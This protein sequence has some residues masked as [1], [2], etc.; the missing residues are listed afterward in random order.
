MKRKVL[1]L[2]PNY[3]NKYPPIGLMK[4]ATYHRMLGD[5]VRFYKG[6]M[7]DFFIDEIFQDCLK[8]LENFAALEIWKELEFE[9]KNFIK[10]RRKNNLEFLSKVNIEKSELITE[11]LLF[12]ANYYK[13]KEYIN[14]PQWDRIFV[15]TL[16]TFYWKKT[17]E[18]IH[19]A[20][21]LVKDG[22]N[23]MVGGVLASLLPEELELETGIKP[24]KGIL[25]R[26]GALDDN[27]IIIDDLP[28]D[29]SILD[30]IDYK[31]PTGSAYFTFMTKGCTRK[32]AFCSV[33]ILEPTYK[34]KIDTIDKFKQI[35]ENYGEQQNLLLMDN[36][37]LA[38]PNFVEIID[39]IKEMGFH[40]GATFVEPNQFE[41][42]IKNLKSGYNDRANTKRCFNLLNQ[43]LKSKSKRKEIAGE[44][45]NTMEKYGLLNLN[46]TTK[47]NL[48][49]AYTEL[50]HLYEKHRKK[51]KKLRY[52]D[53]NQGTDARYVTDELMQKMSE[54]PIRPLRIAFD[55]L[56]ME[57]QY[58]SAVRLAAK[59]DIRDLSN[60]LLFNFKD[61]PGELYRRM[62]IN[63]ELAKELNI[64]IFSFPMKYIPLFGEEAKHRDYVGKHWNKKFIRAIQ[65]ILNVTKGIVASGSNFFHI[66]FGNNLEE[67]NEIL[68]MPETY[69]IYRNVFKDSGLTD[70]WRKEFYR[71]KN[72]DLWE[73]VK[74]IIENSDFKNLQ[75]K[76]SHPELLLFLSHYQVSKNDVMEDDKEIENIRRRFNNL[77]KKDRFV[78]L[79]LTYDYE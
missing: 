78:N 74:Q 14:N 29:Y 45:S 19:A 70:I 10:S 56:G 13:N 17:I 65:S 38:S 47:G 75:E 68:Y 79:T 7:K 62:E 63:I 36:N 39:E 42:A 32:C 11:T 48:I 35:K 31:Y 44:F 16:F 18:T 34:P 37:V 64:N 6:E 27:N 40:K 59:Y 30:E 3:R 25:D 54:I 67:F 12:H 8:E 73:E 50:S 2:E 76:T 23:L 21:H 9:I 71:I 53:F 43:L 55:Y 72:S 46:T 22:K 60:Y 24:F 49:L 66:A 26:R 52:V 69:I 1:L 58:V 4:I 41:I 28:L 57:K 33:P 61:K 5:E 51:S 20:K 77:I 15:T